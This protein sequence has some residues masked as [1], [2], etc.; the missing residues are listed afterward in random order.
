MP[1]DFPENPE[2]LAPSKTLAGLSFILRHKRL[3]PKDFVWDYTD[4]DQCAMGLAAIIFADGDMIEANG[5]SMLEILGDWPGQYLSTGLHHELN[6][7]M[8]DVTPEDVADA[9]DK[10]LVEKSHAEQ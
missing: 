10:Y 2:V 1:F 4:C 3:W 8:D 5:L 9:I 6:K 7:E